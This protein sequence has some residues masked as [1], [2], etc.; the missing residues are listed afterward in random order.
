MVQIGGTSRGYRSIPLART[1]SATE[2]SNRFGPVSSALG[3]VLGS[4][5]SV[6][7]RRRLGPPPS[8]RI[9]NTRELSGSFLYLLLIDCA[10]KGRSVETTGSVGTREGR[11]F[12]PRGCRTKECLGVQIYRNDHPW[13]G[14]RLRRSIETLSNSLFLW[15][16]VEHGDRTNHSAPSVDRDDTL[17]GHRYRSLRE[18]RPV[19]ESQMSNYY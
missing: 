10:V 1:V 15:T 2:V 14:D 12:S 8:V 5:V 9:G 19:Y 6:V 3:S 4:G 7:E 16:N 17:C 11:R 13:F 18:S